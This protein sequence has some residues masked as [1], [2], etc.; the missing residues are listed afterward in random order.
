MPTRP[1]QPKRRA[2]APPADGAFDAAYYARFYDDPR[3]RVSDL[4]TIRKLAAFVAGYL[5]YLDVPVR[6]ILDVGCGRGHWHTAARELWPRAAYRGV[7]YSQHLCERHGWIQGSVT[8][9]DVRRATGREAFDLVVCQGVLQYLDDDG[10]AAALRNLGRWCRGALYLEA[11]TD[12]DWRENCDRSR[13]DGDVHLRSGA[14]YR[15]RLRRD[16]TACGGGVFV[17]RSAGVTLFELEGM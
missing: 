5:R 16:F 15:E 7:E 9:L 1:G 6:S 13:T 14:W 11:L 4:A 17:H 8:D 10:A 3:T 12:Q 2:A